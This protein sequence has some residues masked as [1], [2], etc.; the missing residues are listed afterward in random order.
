MS[1]YHIVQAIWVGVFPMLAAAVLVGALCY[2]LCCLNQIKE[3][4]VHS[5]K[6][7]RLR[8]AARKKALKD[9][10]RQQHHHSLSE[11]IKIDTKLVNGIKSVVFK[12]SYLLKSIYLKYFFFKF[13][14]PNI[15]RLKWK[16]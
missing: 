16:L 12:L 7:R 8:E 1:S 14:N 3:R 6:K 13:L 10:E 2:L 11:P 9:K 15:S 5:R 4:I